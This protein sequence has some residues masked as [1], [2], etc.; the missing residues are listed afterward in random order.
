MRCRTLNRVLVCAVSISQEVAPEA[1][2]AVATSC[3]LLAMAAV[4]D[5]EGSFVGSPAF[6]EVEAADTKQDAPGQYI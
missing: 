1:A 6:G 2:L 3:T 4:V 5:I